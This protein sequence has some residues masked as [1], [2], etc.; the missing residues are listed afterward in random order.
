MKPWVCLGR[1]GVQDHVVVVYFDANSRNAFSWLS[2]VM[3]T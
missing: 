2:F 3:I 1:L